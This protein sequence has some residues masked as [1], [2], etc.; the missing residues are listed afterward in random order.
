M[1]WDATVSHGTHVNVTCSKNAADANGQHRI[2]ISHGTHMHEF[3][4]TYKWVMAHMWMS[5]VT[6]S[7]NAADANGQ[8][9]IWTSHGTHMHESW[10]TYKWVM[11][12][13][14]MSHV[15]CSK[16]A[17][18]ANGQRL[19]QKANG[20]VRRSRVRHYV[21]AVENEKELETSST[22]GFQPLQA[23]IVVCVR[24]RDSKLLC[25]LQWRV[26]VVCR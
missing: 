12:H 7:K 18:D 20:I 14:W 26:A 4:H 25:C 13:M 24:E 9:H 15:T 11:A 3:G 10:H 23:Q 2:R 1:C 8:H 22:S 19:W 17:A 6:C 5:H 21:D 16:N